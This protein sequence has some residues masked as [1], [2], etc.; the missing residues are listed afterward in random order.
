[1]TVEDLIQFLSDEVGVRDYKVIHSQN[2]TD[3]HLERR[4]IQID[5]ARH[6]V[7]L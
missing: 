7:Y 4:D 2:P 5:D 6:E 1:M 3:Y